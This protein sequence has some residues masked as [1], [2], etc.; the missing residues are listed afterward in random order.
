LRTGSQ[1]TS[2]NSSSEHRLMRCATLRGPQGGPCRL[3]FSAPAR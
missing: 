1:N 3:L 2:S